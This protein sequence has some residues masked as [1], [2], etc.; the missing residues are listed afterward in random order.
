MSFSNTMNVNIDFTEDG[1]LV[2]A[3]KCPPEELVD[4]PL[5]S[6]EDAVIPSTSSY[7]YENLRLLK[8]S[9]DANNNAHVTIDI[10]DPVDDNNNNKHDVITDIDGPDWSDIALDGSINS[11]DGSIYQGD[12]EPVSL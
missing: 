12:T 1:A 3:S 8:S 6:T 4:I 11:F 2:K 9:V 10:D 5:D 7:N